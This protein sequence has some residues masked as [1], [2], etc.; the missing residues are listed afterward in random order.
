MTSEKYYHCKRNLK[1]KS[2]SKSMAKCKIRSGQSVCQ[3]TIKINGNSF[4]HGVLITS[5]YQMNMLG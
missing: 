1:S 2:F 4:S 3:K 5:N